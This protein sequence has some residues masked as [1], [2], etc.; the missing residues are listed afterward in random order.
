MSKEQRLIEYSDDIE[1]VFVE[2]PKFERSQDQL[3]NIQQQWI[4]FIKNAGKLD[5]IPQSLN[6]P[7]IRQ[8]FAIINEAGLS[9]E[10]LEAQHKRRDF[11]ILQ[12]DSLT[13]ARSDGEQAGLAKGIEQGIEQGRLAERHAVIRKAHQSGLP[14]Q[15]IASLV[16]L[17]EAELIAQLQGLGL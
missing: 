10:E 8:A 16:G 1:L 3:D 13:K 7:C 2:L 15:L 12:R 4:Y 9:A 11:I 17:S 5:F 6:T 14:P